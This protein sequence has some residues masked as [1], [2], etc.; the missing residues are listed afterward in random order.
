M[1]KKL[2]IFIITIFVT[3]LLL[4]IYLSFF[5][6]TTNKFNKNINDKIQERYPKIN[7]EIKEINLL[8]NPLD[9]TVLLKTQNPKLK[10]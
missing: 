9:F 5:G 3:F 4:I 2:F 7:F 1:K 10:K 8:L 6:I